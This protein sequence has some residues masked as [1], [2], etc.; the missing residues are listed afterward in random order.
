MSVRS[1][2]RAGLVMLCCSAPLQAQQ[3]RTITGKVVDEVSAAPIQ[4]VVVSVENTDLTTLS[5]EQGNFTL[6]VPAGTARLVAHKL[7]YRLTRVDVPT[8]ASTVTIRLETQAVQLKEL[9]VTGQA[10]GVAAAN[11]ANDVA[12]L[13][14]TQVNETPSQSVEDAIQGKVAGITV[15]KNSGAPGGGFT[16][17]IRGKTSFLGSQ[18]PLYVIDGVIVS[19]VSIPPG[20]NLL[21]QAKG[22]AFATSQEDPVNRIS[23]INPRDIENIQVLKGG[24]AAAIYGSKASNGVVIITTNRGRDAGDATRIHFSQQFG[25]PSI[26]AKVGSRKFTSAA[27]AA[28]WGGA[29]AAQEYNRSGGRAFDQD[30]LIAG[31]KPLSTVTAASLSSGSEGQGLY[32]SAV[33]RH[34]GGIVANTFADKQSARLNFDKDLGTR[35]HIFSGLNVIHTRNDRGLT[36][37]DNTG[38][39]LYG[40][41][42]TTPSFFDMRR[43]PDGSYPVNPFA[44]SNPLQ[45]IAYFRKPSDVW[46]FIGSGNVGVDVIKT[47][48][49]QLTLSGNG[50]GDFFSMNTSFFSPPLLQYEPLDGQLGT[51]GETSAQNLNVNVN[52]NAVLKL[53]MGTDMES[54]SQIGLQYEQTD[55]KVNRI[56]AQN[57][58]GGVQN[59]DQATTALVHE[60]REQVK[61]VGLFAQEELLLARRLLLTVGARADRSSANAD[62]GTFFVYPKASVSYRLPL[63]GGGLVN[64]LKLRF[65]FGEAGNEPLFGQKFSSLLG[66]NVSG[67]PGTLIDTQIASD[68]LRPERQVEFEGG[69]DAVLLNS[70]LTVNA[71][72]YQHTVSSLLLRRDLPPSAGFRSEFFN[73]GK[74]RT[75][76]LELSLDG[77]PVQSSRFSWEMRSTFALHRCDITELPVPSFFPG[78]FLQAPLFGVYKFEP[79]KSCTQLVGNDSTAAGAVVVRPFGDSRPN[80]EVNYSTTLTYGGFSAYMLWDW[81]AGGLLFN[82]TQLEL[83]ASGLAPDWNKKGPDG[84]PLPAYRFS[85]WP[86][87]AS[88]YY[89]STTYLKLRQA[90]L[91]WE[92]PQRLV[93][94]VFGRGVRSMRLSLEG[95]NLLL[96]TPYATGDPEHQ[97]DPGNFN[98]GRPW[99]IWT[100]PP[101]RQFWLGVDLSL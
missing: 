37:N 51:A 98:N 19:N 57:L 94:S 18:T 83:D 9:V 61:D 72:A 76:G 46:R 64:S 66:Q 75:R 60:D 39:S 27:D 44:S 74:A 31:R 1:L 24:S 93:R 85:V 87:Q 4:G 6:Q 11:V 16:V 82:V 52:G 59:I 78:Q 15:R 10:T 22:S 90:R 80:F 96:F 92:V 23:D 33:V 69:F 89:Q 91:S 68:S 62:V 25:V 3:P 2:I 73:G 99:D 77:I 67:L 49:K 38:I 8:E 88:V 86:K 50:G 5:N 53:G 13:N 84:Q 97:A 55:L 42:F 40:A 101:A 34:E 32:A 7:G 54:T 26:A 21:T 20:T 30:A 29:T 45:T 63:S 100:Y 58:I 17:D 14:A 12:I 95:S 79:G 65:A 56:F 43:L 47:E 70:R 81:Q 36:G 71:T 48:K 41:L 35:T 28:S